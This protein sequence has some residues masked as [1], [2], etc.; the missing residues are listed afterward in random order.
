[1][2][3]PRKEGSQLGCRPLGLGLDTLVSKNRVVGTRQ[4]TQ[5]LQLKEL[6][7][8]NQAKTQ[9]RGRE[10]HSDLSTGGSVLALWRR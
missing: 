10:T 8:E 6:Q 3:R 9:A 4:R 7:S 2:L 5:R 1:M